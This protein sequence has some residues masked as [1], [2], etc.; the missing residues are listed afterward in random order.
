MFRPGDT[1]TLQLIGLSGPLVPGN[2]V[3]L[4]FAFSNGVP[5]LVVQAPM[6][7]PMSPA[8]RGSADIEEVAEGEGH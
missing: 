5:P 2:S 6:A 3:S 4:I 7:T 8:P 1:R